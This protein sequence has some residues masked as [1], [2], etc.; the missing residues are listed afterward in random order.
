MKISKSSINLF[1]DF[2]FKILILM[3][4]IYMFAAY[5][6]PSILGSLI[7]GEILSKW[8]RRIVL[9]FSV[10]AMGI[11]T[12]LFGWVNIISSKE[13][14][15]FFVWGIRAIEGL[16]SGFIYCAVYSVISITFRENQVKYLAYVEASEAIT[17]I[18]G[19]AVGSS[20][21][22]LPNVF[23]IPSK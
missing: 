10:V 9:F 20:M 4:C 6:I 21:Y 22:Q 17:M 13:T 18:L 16:S 11:S 7:W 23:V 12:I 14:L 19:P 15:I 3:F 2:L 1:L 8:G 5:S